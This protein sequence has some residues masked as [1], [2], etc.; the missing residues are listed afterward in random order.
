MRYITKNILLTLLLIIALLF[1][2]WVTRLSIEINKENNRTDTPDAFMT[3]VRYLSFDDQGQWDSEFY[4]P[5]IEHYH[6]RDIAILEKPHVTS[7]GDNDLT[8]TI[9]A[10]QGMSYDGGKTVVLKENVIIERFNDKTQARAQMSTSE[11][12]LYPKKK[13]LQTKEPVRIKQPGSLIEAV[14]FTADLTTG[15]IQ[16]SS[17]SKGTLAP[18]S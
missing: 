18:S 17:Q 7:R 4:A 11:I 14:G 3:D 6:T 5:E 12:T 10:N 1:S 2:V 13:Y 9:T 16:L 8:W 15:D